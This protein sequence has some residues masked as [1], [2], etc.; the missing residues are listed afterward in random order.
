MSTLMLWVW[1][2]QTALDVDEVGDGCFRRRYRRYDLN[3]G[4]VRGAERCSSSTRGRSPPSRRAA[5]RPGRVRP[6]GALGGIKQPWHSR[7]RLSGTSESSKRA[8]ST[9]HSALA[10]ILPKVDADRQ[11]WEHV[12]LRPMLLE[13]R[14]RA[15]APALRE[16]DDE[17]VAPLTASVLVAPN[18][19]VT[20]AP[21]PRPGDRVE[22]LHLGRGHTSNDLVVAPAMPT[23]VSPAILLEQ[24]R[25]RR[26]SATTATRWSGRRRWSP[27]EIGRSRSCRDTA[28]S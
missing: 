2:G 25:R 18:D 6:P 12:D 27:V 11:P 13:Q 20:E 8:R 15:G 3:I 10:L 19:L 9:P 22:P 26:R 17:D 16:F 7:S 23:S 5:R 28:T 1:R 4:V 21:R 24:L 14:G